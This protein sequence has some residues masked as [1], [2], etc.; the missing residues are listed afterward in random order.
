MASS[1]DYI[2]YIR[3]HVASNSFF[4]VMLQSLEA[5]QIIAATLHSQP[6]CDC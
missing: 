5:V 3:W 2:L 6:F 4:V 1:L